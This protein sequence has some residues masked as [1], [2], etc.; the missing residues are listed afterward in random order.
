MDVPGLHQPGVGQRHG[1]VRCGHD[2]QVFSGLVNAGPAQVVD[3]A[4]RTMD[5]GPPP[6]AS[7]RG[8]RGNSFRRAEPVDER[9]YRQDGIEDL[10]ARVERTRSARE[11]ERVLAELRHRKTTARVADLLDEADGKRSQ[12][13]RKKASRRK[14]GT[15]EHG[16]CPDCSGEKACGGVHVYAIELPPEAAADSKLSGKSGGTP[17]YIGSSRYTEPCLFRQHQASHLRE[18]T[19]T[20]TC[21]DKAKE[22]EPKRRSLTAKYGPVRLRLDLTEGLNPVQDGPTAEQVLAAA[23]RSRFLVYWN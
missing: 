19:Y 23:L 4:G 12:L 5:N 13:L 15:P 9:P 21:F 17:L 20:C 10:E 6:A 3:R 1:V 16:G 7:A 22:R 8:E 2:C 14:P 18:P 11:V